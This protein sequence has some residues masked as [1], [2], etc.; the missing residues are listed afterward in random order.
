MLRS[1]SLDS[2]VAPTPTP[3][4]S[5]SIASPSGF[6]F[7]G[8]Y[9]P[10]ISRV[11]KGSASTF[12]T[13]YSEATRKARIA[14]VTTF[15]VRLS[16]GNNNNDGLSAAT[17]FRSLR[18]AVKMGVDTGQPFT[19]NYEAALPTAATPIVYRDSSTQARSGQATNNATWGD[20][21]RSTDITQDCVLEPSVAGGVAYN[22]YTAISP[23]YA[24]S[25]DTNTYVATV[26][27]TTRYS[28]IY[29]FANLD[30]NNAP[31][32]LAKLIA[33]PADAAN[34]WP[35]INALWTALNGVTDA[36]QVPA[37]GLGVVWTDVANN[38]IYVRTFN[39]RAPDA[40]LLHGSLTGNLP[41]GINATPTKAV[42]A[43][44]EGLRFIGGSAGGYAAFHLYAAGGFR[45]QFD[46]VRCGFHGGVGA[47][48]LQVD[49]SAATD[50][51][52]TIAVGCYA[53][54]ALFDGFNYHQACSAIELGCTSDWN[55]WES[56]LANNGTTCHETCRVIRVSGSY[57]QNQDRSLHDVHQAMSWN[58]GCES[59]TRRGQDGAEQSA[60]FATGRPSTS[61]NSTI[62]LDA[63]AVLNGAGGAPQYPTESYTSATLRYANLSFVPTAGPGTGTV[64]A[65]EA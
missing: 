47:G 13:D 9:A 17:A 36:G 38:K 32:P 65:Y 24:A 61:D 35:E 23:N 20:C 16:T 49:G 4:P 30:R 62:W 42:R 11:G 14:P 40:N 25:S 29:D 52:D 54:N 33:A 59:S 51:S 10:T 63:C 1:T 28:Q 6:A 60:A 22:A 41:A 21:W 19:V 57:R 27:S 44:I 53:S 39:N 48:A 37:Y 3:T 56:G 12:S 58:L 2:G 55:G 45:H 64:S 50:G 46:F 5:A 15:Y 18:L 7:S 43:Y 8:P 31:R 34:P 26:T